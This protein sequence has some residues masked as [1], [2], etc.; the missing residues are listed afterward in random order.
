MELKIKT[1]FALKFKNDKQFRQ[2]IWDK[3]DIR[4]TCPEQ[5]E[6]QCSLNSTYKQNVKYS[7]TF[8][9][10]YSLVNMSNN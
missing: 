1:K 6:K 2:N 9:I 3:L 5:G 7:N 10:P 8:K 4:E